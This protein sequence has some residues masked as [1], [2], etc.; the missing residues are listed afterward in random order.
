MKRLWDD[1]ELT[2]EWTLEPSDQPLLAN[3]TGATRL[4]FAA[5]LTFFA[6]K[7]VFPPASTRCRLPS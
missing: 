5:L 1:D 6:T 3:K 7:A 4:G 2:T